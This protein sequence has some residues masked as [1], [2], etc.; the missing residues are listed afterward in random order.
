MA[1]KYTP[2]IGCVAS[3][4][5]KLLTQYF[6]DDQVKENK[7][8]GEF[9]TCGERRGAYRLL[10]W[11]PEGK[12]SLWRTRHRGTKIL[13]W[14][15][16]NKMRVM[17]WIY[18]VQDRDRLRAVVHADVNFQV[19][20]KA[21]NFLTSWRPVSFSGRTVHGVSHR[22]IFFRINELTHHNS[23][24]RGWYATPAVQTAVEG[25]RYTSRYVESR[26]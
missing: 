18:L 5:K 25:V 7:M 14:I 22:H 6:S 9:S 12:S 8:G 10:V 19:P 20:S 3:G 21:E 23:M 13:K 11:K 16:K 2:T 1:V 24:L 15:F 26:C 17:E 4:G